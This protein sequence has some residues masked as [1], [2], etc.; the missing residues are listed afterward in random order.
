MG[1]EKNDNNGYDD[2]RANTSIVQMTQGNI[3]TI[4]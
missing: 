1:D 4:H 2:T 3:S